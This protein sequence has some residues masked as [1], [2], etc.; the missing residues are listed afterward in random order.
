[1]TD[2][3]HIKLTQGDWYG[4]QMLPGYGSAYHAYFSPIYVTEVKPLKSGKHLLTLSFF[5]AHYAKGVADF[6]LDLQILKRQPQYLI[7]NLVYPNGP[8]DRAAIIS[9]ISFAWLEKFTPKV[10]DERE[11]GQ[12]SVAKNNVQRYLDE[13]YLPRAAWRDG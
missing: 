1:M 6:M 7:A 12:S 8:Q 9:L 5:N 11:R 13:L 2:F 4:W 10:L 3:E